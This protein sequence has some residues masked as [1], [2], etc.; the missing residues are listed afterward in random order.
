MDPSFHLLCE[1]M[2]RET[3]LI[4]WSFGGSICAEHGVGIENVDRLRN[5]ISDV[6]M[7]LMTQLKRTFDPNNMMNPGK[8]LK[9]A[10]LT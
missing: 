10:T 1:R 6:E 4:V 9:Q 7:G 5:Q 2:I 8:V 3:D